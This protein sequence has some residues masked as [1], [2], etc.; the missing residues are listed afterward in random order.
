MEGLKCR[1]AENSLPGTGGQSYASEVS[2]KKAFP[3]P[4]GGRNMQTNV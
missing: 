2:I 1:A 4:A 3:F